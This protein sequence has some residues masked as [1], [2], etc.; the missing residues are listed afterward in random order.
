MRKKNP[1]KKTK[2]VKENPG[3]LDLCVEQLKRLRSLNGKLRDVGYDATDIKIL[4]KNSPKNIFRN[5]D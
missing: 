5:T 1:A 3:D 4:E 2:N